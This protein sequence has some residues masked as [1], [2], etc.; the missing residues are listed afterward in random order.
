MKTVSKTNFLLTWQL[1]YFGKNTTT[2][3]DNVYEFISPNVYQYNVLKKSY[4]EYVLCNDYYNLTYID[5]VP[6]IR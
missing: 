5:S 3:D 6:G 4:F 2:T 1:R